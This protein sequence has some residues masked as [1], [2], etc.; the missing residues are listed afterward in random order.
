M[1][2]AFYDIL[3]NDDYAQEF[4]YVSNDVEDREKYIIDDDSDEENDNAQCNKTRM[5]LNLAY[6]FQ[7]DRKTFKFKQSHFNVSN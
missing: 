1:G 7:Q 5:M 3:A 2:V 4:A 6:F